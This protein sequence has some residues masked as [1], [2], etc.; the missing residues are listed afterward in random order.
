MGDRD[1]GRSLSRGPSGRTERQ[2]PKN[3]SL[4]AGSEVNLRGIFG[5]SREEAPEE[6]IFL[7][8]DA[9]SEHFGAKNEAGR[10]SGHPMKGRETSQ[11]LHLRM[12]HE[13]TQAELPS[14]RKARESEALTS[15]CD[16]KR[17]LS[18]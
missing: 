6:M 18:W 2:Q 11:L 9:V 7:L 13:R 10:R 17:R 5:A 1:G 15:R 16:G 3:R 4:P 8:R 14:G 12:K